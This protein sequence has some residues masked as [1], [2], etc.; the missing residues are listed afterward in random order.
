MERDVVVVVTLG[1]FFH[2]TLLADVIQAVA[3][4][5]SEGGSIGVRVTADYIG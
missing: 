1:K 4:G 3:D 5:L 2:V